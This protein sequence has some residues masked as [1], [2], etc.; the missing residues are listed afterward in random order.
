MV[1][2][3]SAV[4]NDSRPWVVPQLINGCQLL[5]GRDGSLRIQ[6]LVEFL[7]SSRHLS[8]HIG[9]GR[10]W[11]ARH[12]NNNNNNN[13]NKVY[14]RLNR[15]TTFF[16]GCVPSSQSELSLM[17]VRLRVTASPSPSAERHLR[18][19][20]SDNLRHFYS[21]RI[22]TLLACDLL[23][24]RC[25]A[26]VVFLCN[27]STINFRYDCMIWRWG[28]IMSEAKSDGDD[29]MTIRWWMQPYV[30][31]AILNVMRWDTDNHWS[32]CRNVGVMWSFHR[33]PVTSRAAA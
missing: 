5:R 16:H 19:P 12:D 11:R 18:Q 20:S 32:M 14:V 28:T 2:N 9:L 6:S 27:G 21:L 33:T 7:I 25:N 13:N 17:R 24:W 1:D 4:G 30:I 22:L 10:A 8:P 3:T 23:Y 31:N 15:Q 29:I 26:P